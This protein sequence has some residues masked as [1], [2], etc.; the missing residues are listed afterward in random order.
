MLLQVLTLLGFNAMATHNSILSTISLA[1]IPAI[2]LEVLELKIFDCYSISIIFV[3]NFLA[4]KKI[5]FCQS[6]T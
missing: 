1:S 4:K 5:H 3:F 2:T 6:S